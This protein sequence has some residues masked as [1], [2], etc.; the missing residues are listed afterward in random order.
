MSR[1]ISLL[2]FGSKSKSPGTGS[3]SE[4]KEE[5]MSLSVTSV[6]SSQLCNSSHNDSESN[7]LLKSLDD[8]QHL[9]LTTGRIL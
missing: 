3:E 7:L 9:G 5:D 6:H 1:A 2:N 4:K 8:D